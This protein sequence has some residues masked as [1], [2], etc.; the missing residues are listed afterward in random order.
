QAWPLLG[1]GRRLRRGRRRRGR[2]PDAVAELLARE[3]RLA[4]GRCV[5]EFERLEFVVPR[6]RDRE[7]AVGPAIGRLENLLQDAP[8]PEEETEVFHKLDSDLGGIP[9]I[10]H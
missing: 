8:R 2:R 10:E 6:R 7:I 9:R 3:R 5:V 1:G 4:A